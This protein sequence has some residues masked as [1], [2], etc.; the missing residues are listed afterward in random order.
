VEANGDQVIKIISPHISGGM[1]LSD[2]E[3]VPVQQQSAKRVLIC[4]RLNVNIPICEVE[5]F[6]ENKF[7]DAKE[8]FPHA[9]VMAEAICKAWNQRAKNTE[10]EK[11][12][13]WAAEFLATDH[14]EPTIAAE[15]LLSA[16]LTV[17]EFERMAVD[18]DKKADLINEMK[19][20]LTKQKRKAARNQRKEV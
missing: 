20:Q 14:D 15:M 10:F 17:E 7:S 4:I 9:V 5:M 18:F 2:V 16:G 12:V 19:C 6:T 13:A 1:R 3:L 8:A 11:G